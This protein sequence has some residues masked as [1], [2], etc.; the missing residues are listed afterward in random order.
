MTS[1]PHEMHEKYYEGSETLYNISMN[2]FHEF[3]FLHLYVI[4]NKFGS[5]MQIQLHRGPICFSHF[6]YEAFSPE[7]KKGKTYVCH[8]IV[9]LSL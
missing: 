7:I 5:D 2:I 4:R 8:F 9:P 1:L 6:L 3:I